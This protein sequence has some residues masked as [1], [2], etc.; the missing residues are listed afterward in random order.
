MNRSKAVHTAVILALALSATHSHA[1][2]VFVGSRAE[3]AG[4]DS[5]D[6]GDLVP[7]GFVFSAPSSGFS[8][9]TTKGDPVWVYPRV[10]DQSD[11]EIA[12]LAGSPSVRTWDYDIGAV[13]PLVRA[14]AGVV[15]EFSSPVK[16]AGADFSAYATF[17]GSPSGSLA[18]IPYGL[19]GDSLGGIVVS[20]FTYSNPS[21]TGFAGIR[22]DVAEITKI[23]FRS[24]SGAGSTLAARF[25][26][27]EVNRV[28]L[29]TGAPQVA[30][31]EPSSLVAVLGMGLAA[32]V[33]LGARRRR[34]DTSAR[35]A[36]R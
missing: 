32:V 18:I 36:I 14:G 29:V 7:A 21:Y 25:A 27:F 34:T 33:S 22:S 31:P 13:S 28:D 35:I 24:L 26:S 30:V 11:L 4:D 2:I 10:S 23:E 6:W 9:S 20:D 1:E 17:G 15:L 12:S 3:L 8:M 16:G 19:S 5:L